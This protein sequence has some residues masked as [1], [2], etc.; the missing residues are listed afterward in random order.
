LEDGMPSLWPTNIGEKR[1]TLSK[2][3]GIKVWCYWEQVEENI[4]NL[5]NLMGTHYEKKNPINHLC[6]IVCVY[7]G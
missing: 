1:T 6:F 5:G 2:A 4:S 3:Y 7:I